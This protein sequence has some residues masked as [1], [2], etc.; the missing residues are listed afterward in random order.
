M[1][2][3]LGS[4]SLLGNHHA[5]FFRERKR[6]QPP[7]HTPVAKRFEPTDNPDSNRFPDFAANSYKRLYVFHVNLYSIY[8]G[9][10]HPPCSKKASDDEMDT[11]DFAILHDHLPNCTLADKH[12]ISSEVSFIDCHV[13]AS[14]ASLAS[15]SRQFTVKESQSVLFNCLQPLPFH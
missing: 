5:H 7:T 6:Q 12:A 1:V 11:M 9:L 15:T 4:S 13:P 3:L 2:F 14:L 10:Y 8:W